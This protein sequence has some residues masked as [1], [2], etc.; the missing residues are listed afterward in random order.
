ML[1]G[2][3][4]IVAGP[5]GQ[6]WINNSGN[7]AMATAGMGDVLTGLIAALL[8]RGWSAR[9]ALLAGVHLHGLAGDHIC[10]AH[11]IDSGLL[12]DELAPSARHCFNAW[13]HPTT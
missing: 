3:G 2:C 13:I 6:W 5:D 10:A 9:D 1:K 8:A 4:S 12:A 11:G 7:P